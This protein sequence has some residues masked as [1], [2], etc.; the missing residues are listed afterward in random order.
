MKRDMYNEKT[1]DH[2]STETVEIVINVER[3]DDSENDEK[4]GGLRRF[5]RETLLSISNSYW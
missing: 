5:D 3:V 4:S 2:T 1:D